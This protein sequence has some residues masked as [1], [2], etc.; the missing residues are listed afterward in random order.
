MKIS[1]VFLLGIVLCMHYSAQAMKESSAQQTAQKVDAGRCCICLESIGHNAV[2]CN[3]IFE[4]GKNGSKH[5]YHADCI[6]RWLDTRG[7]HAFCPICHATALR[8]ED[9]ALLSAAQAGN[10]S[11][12]AA[13]I[14]DGAV[15]AVN[16]YAV[17]HVAALHKHAHIVHHCFTLDSTIDKNKLL[18]DAI[19]EKNV[20]L[21]LILVEQD[22]TLFTRILAGHHFDLAQEL[23][24]HSFLSHTYGPF[25]ATEMPQLLCDAVKIDADTVAWLYQNYPI[26][27]AAFD[28][29]LKLAVLQNKIDIVKTLASQCTTPDSLTHN[30]YLA[31]QTGK[32]EILRY[33]IEEK[34]IPVDILNIFLEATKTGCLEIV[35]YLCIHPSVQNYLENAIHLAAQYDDPEHSEIMNLLISRVNPRALLDHTPWARTGQR[36]GDLKVLKKLFETQ[37]IESALV[38]EKAAQALEQQHAAIAQYLIDEQ[39]V[40]MPHILL[41][42]QQ[43]RLARAVTSVLTDHR[44]QI[45]VNSA[46][47]QSA[48]LGGDQHIFDQFVE[49]CSNQEVLTQAL[50]LAAKKNN[51]PMVTTLL[52]KC[53]DES[54]A[55]TLHHAILFGL[56]DLTR[57][58]IQQL[59][60]HHCEVD[61]PAALMQI[62]HN[63]NL[64]M[65]MF[66]ITEYSIEI[67]P[68]QLKE[69]I[70]DAGNETLAINF[71]GIA[72]SFENTH[73]LLCH[74]A[75][76]GRFEI[77]KFLLE[78]RQSAEVIQRHLDEVVMW[79]QRFNHPEIVHHL[80]TAYPTRLDLPQLA[81]WAHGIGAEELERRITT[82]EPSAHT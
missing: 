25:S 46:L 49:L 21:L 13:A 47:L 36:P 81:A 50:I 59:H 52:A 26:T 57:I 75:R 9:R 12:L 22:H 78:N 8:A 44:D 17:L 71:C 3:Q 33:F 64:Q 51:M 68:Q 43:K 30:T 15:L 79:A 73:A 20:Q 77:L 37:H 72:P 41:Q 18:A 48:E 67:D 11:R 32:A 80:I 82:T 19:D 66:F 39:H 35:R 74:A 31:A 42:A 4:S 61:L 60:D 54:L 28:T 70:I 34:H 63:G 1:K 10:L 27:H 7:D 56:I 38:T 76:A 14:K 40:L 23:L 24:K 62:V 53:T 45:D 58:I 2:T 55:T 65:L 16:E 6:Q 5:S 69:Q 29:T